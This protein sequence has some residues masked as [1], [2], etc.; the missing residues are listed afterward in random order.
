MSDTD[1]TA[2]QQLAAAASHCLITKTFEADV[3][4]LE[5]RVV[6]IAED[7]PAWVTDLCHEAHGDLMPDDWRFEFISL[8]LDALGEDKPDTARDSATDPDARYPYTADRLRWL[9][10]HLDRPGY[11]DEAA[12]EYSARNADIVTQVAWGMA[13]ELGEVFDAVRQHLE[14]MV[15]GA[16][17]DAPDGARLAGCT[18]DGRQWA[19]ADDEA[20]LTTYRPIDDE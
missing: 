18:E 13:R 6:I 1:T 15:E 16:E 8:A 20:G 12:E 10:S 11:C 9:A 3:G 17:D 5:R 14:E 7:S 4:R 19:Y 2:L